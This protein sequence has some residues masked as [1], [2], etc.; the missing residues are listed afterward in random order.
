MG[1]DE[2][3]VDILLRCVLAN[4][5]LVREFRILDLFTQNADIL[6]ILEDAMIERTIRTAMEGEYLGGLLGSG[7][8]GHIVQISCQ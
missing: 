3:V 2:G 7:L 6:V 8:D 1:D 4:M 5:T